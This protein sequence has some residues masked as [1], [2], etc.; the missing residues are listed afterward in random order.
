MQRMLSARMLEVQEDAPTF[1]IR[2]HRAASPPS[3]DESYLT[4]AAAVPTHD[5]VIT[6]VRRQ[7]TEAAQQL[8]SAAFRAQSSTQFKYEPAKNKTQALSLI[9]SLQ[10]A[11]GAWTL[12]TE[13]AHILGRSVEKLKTACPASPCKDEVELVWATA[14]VLCYLEK[15][16]LERK[17]E[18]E[19]LAVKA[20]EWLCQHVP[21]G[22]TPE[23]FQEQAEKVV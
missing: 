2:R 7:F 15:R 18:W 3:D 16:H 17:D 22:Y 20:S 14:L 5:D 11:S 9:I 19:L 1:L 23:V 21:E 10:L 12:T 13:L 6:S 8:Q 4:E